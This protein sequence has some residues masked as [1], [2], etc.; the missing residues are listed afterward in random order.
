MKK[1][2]FVAIVVAL[3]CVSAVAAADEKPKARRPAAA[4]PNVTLVPV[5][6]VVKQRPIVSVA[7]QREKPRLGVRD[8]KPTLVDRIEQDSA[9]EPF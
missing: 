9:K 1:S 8:L 6:I 2:A 7:I 3:G 5:D 4:K